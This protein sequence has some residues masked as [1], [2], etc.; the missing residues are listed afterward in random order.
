MVRQTHLVLPVSLVYGHLHVVKRDC[1]WRGRPGGAGKTF[2][3]TGATVIPIRVSG[4]KEDKE[5]YRTA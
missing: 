2:L 3:Y 1:H 4:E 5:S